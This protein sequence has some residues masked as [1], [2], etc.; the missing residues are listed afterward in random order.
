MI[1]QEHED[2]RQA[3]RDMATRHV[4][5]LAN[6]IDRTDKFPEHLIEIFGDMGLIQLMVP[7]QYGGP[8][9]DLLS[10]CL[11]REEVAQAGSMALAQ[12]AGQNNIVVNALM[13]SADQQVLDHLLPRLARGRTLT[14]IAITEREAGSD[15]SLMT[16]RARRDGASWVINGAKQFIT[17]GSIAHYALV[18][19][20]TNDAPGARGI[21]AF[22]VDTDQPG[23]Q[24]TKANDKMGQHGVPNNEIL[25]ENVRVPAEFMVGTEGNGF[26]AAMHGLHL[27]RPT[28]AGIAVG[29]AQCALDYAISY[30]RERE[31]GGHRVAEYQGLRWMMAEDHTHIEAA[32]LL[33][34]R[35]ASAWDAGAAPDEV[36]RLSSMAKLF[37]ADTVNRVTANAVQILG[38]HGYMTDHP[39]ERY[40]RDAKLLGIY[41]GT[42]QIQ[43]NIIAK[44]ILR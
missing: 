28:V 20:R 4:A 37:A 15:P 18:F 14:C 3:V 1:D 8:G 38:G 29:G 32:R 41:E 23:W 27:N 36:T 31:A 43:R 25:L 33:V 19:A 21:S 2:F 6:E 5:P 24:V 7:E 12:L 22:L 13:T 9:G 39:V 10:S 34:Y 30:A 17:W 11:A 26:G 44:R 16:T 40:M 35:C 42:S